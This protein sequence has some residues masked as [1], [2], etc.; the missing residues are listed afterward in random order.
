M[1]GKKTGIELLESVVSKI[2]KDINGLRDKAIILLIKVKQLRFYRTSVVLQSVFRHSR[3]PCDTMVLPRNS[4]Q[5]LCPVKALEE[6][7]DAAKLTD[8]FLWR[9]AHR[10]TPGEPSSF[11]LD[12]VVKKHFG[13]WFA[14]GNMDREEITGEFC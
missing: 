10:K 3:N 12:G 4:S 6:W 7:I 13:E 9:N 1:D 5:H 2:P 11:L 14:C 8:G